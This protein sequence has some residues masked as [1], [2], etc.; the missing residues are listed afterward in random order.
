MPGVPDGHRVP[1]G[2]GVPDAEVVVGD[3]DG[4]GSDSTCGSTP[5]R[6]NKYKAAMTTAAII[7]MSTNDPTIACI[8]FRC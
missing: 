3:S 5:G 1:D 2:H 6:A 4:D 8:R 7:L